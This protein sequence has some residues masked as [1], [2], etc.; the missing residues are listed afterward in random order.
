[1]SRIALGV[2]LAMMAVSTATAHERH[3]HQVLGVIKS[4]AP[5]KLEV[6][7]KAEGAETEKVISVVLTE[8]TRILRGAR[9]VSVSDLQ[10]GERV[11]LRVIENKGTVT[12]REVRVA[13]R[14]T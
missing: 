3:E 14:A 13:P 6:L 10:V 7:S 11:V 9:P 8:Q 1:M 4:I 5:G 12:A 2:V